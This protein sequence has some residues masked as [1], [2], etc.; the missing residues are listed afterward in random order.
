MLFLPLSIS[1]NAISLTRS[2]IDM[3]E[4]AMSGMQQ[5]G[6]G[7]GSI[8]LL[9]VI[10]VYITN[11]LDGGKF[12]VKMLLPLLIYICVCNFRLIAS[13]VINFATTIQRSCV[14]ACGNIQDKFMNDMTG[15]KYESGQAFSLWHALLEKS[16]STPQ[17]ELEKKIASATSDAGE[18]NDDEADNDDNEESPKRFSFK[19]LGD[20]IINA[21]HKFKD[22]V[23][24]QFLSSF[25]HSPGN[26]I[27]YGLMG[28]VVTVLD[29]VAQLLNIALTAM[30]AVMTAIVV[31]F[32]PITWAF[33]IF[34][35][36]GKTIGAW[37]IRIC[38]FVLYSPIVA[39]IQAF[40][41]TCLYMFT[42]GGMSSSV[43]EGSATV[44]AAAGLILGLIAAL[45]SVPAIASMIIEGAQGA[46]TISQG[47]MTASSLS[48][49]GEPFRDKK[50]QNAINNTGG[51]PSGGNAPSGPGTS[52]P[53][54]LLNGNN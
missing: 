36:N 18:V 42:Q 19:G 20:N 9:F 25:M 3:A 24:G 2:V 34:P 52:A 21:L 15:G 32:G 1:D 39:L 51:G 13:P 16:N 49:L 48:Q 17:S 7:I 54:G 33:A 10:F 31:A 4:P 29:W 50:M 5:I 22:T 47:L 8:F 27:V 11:I 28:F 45:M 14:D 30:G 40:F 35:G 53:S 26:A 43:T 23:V 46:V 37:A 38:Q 6:K 41:T 12:Q 44:L